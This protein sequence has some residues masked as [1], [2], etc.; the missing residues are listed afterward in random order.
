MSDTEKELDC[1]CSTVKVIS[2][3]TKPNSPDPEPVPVKVE[4]PQIMFEMNRS[5]NLSPVDFETSP[6]IVV[7]FDRI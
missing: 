4:P 2:L 1:T 7:D 6:V 3:T 5:P